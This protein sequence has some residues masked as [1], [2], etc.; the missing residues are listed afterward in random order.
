MPHKHLVALAHETAWE[1]ASVT[2]LCQP[3]GCNIHNF[4]KSKDLNP[5]LTDT[6]PPRFA[7]LPR[8]SRKGETH[9]FPFLPCRGN[10]AMGEYPKGVGVPCPGEP[11]QTCA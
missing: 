8:A 6:P 4:Y 5:D 2:L 10:A 3:L 7:V 1:S 11:L 9:H